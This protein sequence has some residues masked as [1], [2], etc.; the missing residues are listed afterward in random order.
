MKKLMFVFAVALAAVFVQAASVTW[1]TGKIY[2]PGDDGSG[3]SSSLITG[4]GYTATIAFFTYDSV[5]DKYDPFAISAGESSSTVNMNAIKGTTGD[6]FNTSGT[7]YAQLVVTYGEST[8]TSE[9][10]AFD[11][12]TASS[13]P[14]VTLKF[15]EGD[16]FNTSGSKFPTAGWS[17]ADVPEPTSGLL[18]LVGGAMLA[19]RRRRA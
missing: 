7:Y 12:D 19:L 18:L 11:V 8:L 2:A 16:G 15:L 5:N 3:Y 4:S 17:G 1:N 14:N 9:I 13:D 10:A 6:D